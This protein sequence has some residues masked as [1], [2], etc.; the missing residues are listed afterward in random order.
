M[1]NEPAEFE[2]KPAPDPNN[3]EQDKLPS[4]SESKSPRNSQV[5]LSFELKPGARVSVTVE[6]IPTKPGITLPESDR[7]GNSNIASIRGSP[8]HIILEGTSDQGVIQANVVL[9]EEGSSQKEIPALGKVI[10]QTGNEEPK[11]LQETPLKASKVHQ[12]MSN[13]GSWLDRINNQPITKLPVILF[14]ASGI[15]YLVIHLVGLLKFPIYFFCDEAADTLQAADLVN[16]GF[17]DFRGDLF[18]TFFQN[19]GQFSLGTSVYLKIIPYILFGRSDWMVRF[20]TVLVSLVAVLWVGLILR[21][22]FKKSYWWS[23]VLLLGV[24]PTWFLHTRT[25]FEVSLMVTLYTGFIYYYLLYRLR[26]PRYL[27]VSLVLGGLAFYAYTPGEIIMVVSGV[28]LLI[29]D[30]RYHWQQRKIGLYGVGVLVLLA[31]P[32]ARFIIQHPVDYF[33]RLSLYGSYLIGNGTAIAKIRTYFITWL[34]GLNP[35]YWFFSN[36]KDLPIYTMKGYGHIA[37]PTLP[38]VA[39]GLWQTLKRMGQSEYRLL[40]L[41]ILAAPTGAAVA[42]IDVN[43][44]QVIVIPV[45]MLMVLGLETSL[46]WIKKKIHIPELTIS[47]GVF[48]VLSVCSLLMLR[49][50][51]V[52][53]P[54]WYTDYGLSGMQYG[55]RQVFT[56]AET[57]HLA[58]PDDQIYISPNWSFQ[59]NALLRFYLGDNSPIQI[60]TVDASIEQVNPT[61]QNTLFV[62]TPDDYQKV[63]DSG[64]FKSITPDI[65]L[66]YPDG[67]PGFYFTHLQYQDNIQQILAAIVEKRHELTYGSITLDGETVTVGYSTLDLGTIEN[68]FDGNPSTLIRTKEANPLVIELDFPQPKLLSGVTVRVGAEPVRLTAYLTV[69][70]NTQPIQYSVDAGEV[71]NYKDVTLTFDSP[72]MVTKLRLEV[73]DV[74][75]PEPTNIHVWEVTLK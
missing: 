10:F 38:F 29:S 54:T 40:L 50:V 30:W 48:L 55:A 70:D 12:L 18:P 62:L 73:L 25:G 14:A 22:I 1:T 49:D 23:G 19:G 41:V 39:L 69:G 15:V 11:K 44:A 27:F 63:V 66:P 67:K 16:N 17:R 52:N 37:W 21:D 42:A 59:T 4:S 6:S 74:L 47:V 58:H 31:A 45:L 46:V 3:S 51:L 60:G 56:T 61:I 8:A 71:Q 36:S 13:I 24:T 5:Q 34:S 72:V 9:P 43:R 26:N 2:E 7:S 33:N 20:I 68:A 65:V 53:G 32:L 75:V 35:L 28:L 64:E 57:Y